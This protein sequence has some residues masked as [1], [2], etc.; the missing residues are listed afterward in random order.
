MRAILFF[1]ALATLAA[2]TLSGPAEAY[3]RSRTDKG[4]PIGWPGSCTWIRLDTAGAMDLPIDAVEKTLA[5]AVANWQTMSTDAGKAYLKITI[6]PPAES[7]ARLDHINV[8]KF[9]RD[10][11]CR[12]AEEKTKENCYSAQATAITTIFYNS[13][14]GK[15]GDGDIVDADIQMNEI[16]FTFVQLPS[17]VMARAGTVRA[18][19]ENT[20]TH[21]LGHFQGLDHTCRDAAS[22]GEPQDEKG[23]KVPGCADVLAMKVPQDEYQRIVQATMFNFAVPAETIK[24]MPKADDIAGIAGIYAPAIDPKSCERP[25]DKK[26]GCDLG[27][28]AGAVPLALLFVAAALVLRARRRMLHS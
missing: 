4:T 5:K 17:N 10:K 21:E 8:V 28:R 12:P 7:E 3:V 19:L 16:N 1:A 26:S 11:W 23:N 18:D 9:R 13:V 14:P 24:R 27:G 15:E 20:L 2:A 25:T 22:N 6:D